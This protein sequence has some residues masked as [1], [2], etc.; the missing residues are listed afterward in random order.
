MK[1][2]AA[3]LV[4]VASVNAFA[5][6]PVLIATTA[7]G[8]TQFYGHPE[9]FNADNG[10]LTMVVTMRE[11]ASTRFESSTQ[12]Q[13]GVTAYDCARGTGPLYTR[14]SADAA[15]DNPKTVSISSPKTVAD[16]LA[17]TLCEVGKILT[18]AGVDL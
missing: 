11:R 14:P 10:N 15:W 6:E 5:A 3:A 2:L 1:K 12:A 7:D 4:L 13:I 16:R 8:E 9:T 18:E 17:A